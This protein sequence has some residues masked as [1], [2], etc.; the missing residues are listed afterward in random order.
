MTLIVSVLA[1]KNS[2]MICDRMHSVDGTL[3]NPVKATVQ[4][5]DLTLNINSPKLRINSG[6]KIYKYNNELIGGAG[7][8]SKVQNF[9][10]KI[11]CINVEN[12]LDFTQKYYETHREKAPDQLMILS[13]SQNIFKLNVY[14]IY[15]VDELYSFTNHFFTNNKTNIGVIAIGSGS[16]LFLQMYNSI[17]MKLIKE[18]E[19]ELSEKNFIKK[20]QAIYEDVSKYND[21]VSSETNVYNI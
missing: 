21:W 20:I 4:L 2:F 18:Y 13:Q 7:N 1:K 3:E 6:T 9:M 10:N 17:K 15:Q 16:K 8:Y 14:S 5:D 19:S 11:D 12:I